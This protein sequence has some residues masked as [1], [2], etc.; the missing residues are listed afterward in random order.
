MAKIKKPKKEDYEKESKGQGVGSPNG[1][2]AGGTNNTDG[3]R[4]I[5]NARG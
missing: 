1:H 5:S 4:V 3:T 2:H